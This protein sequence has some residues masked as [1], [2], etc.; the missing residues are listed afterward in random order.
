MNR[1]K[2]GGGG[3]FKSRGVKEMDLWNQYI[4]LKK[5]G[6]GE[7]KEVLEERGPRTR[8]FVEGTHKGGW[9]R[10]KLQRTRFEKRV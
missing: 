7:K 10:K 3:T 6:G 5:G 1:P 4:S 8:G 9:C 2:G